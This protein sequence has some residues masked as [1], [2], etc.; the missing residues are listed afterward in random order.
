MLPIFITLINH[1]TY[2]QIILGQNW[3]HIQEGDCSRCTTCIYMHVALFCPIIIIILQAA[4]LWWALNSQPATLCRMLQLVA[5]ES[6]AVMT[7]TI[8]VEDRES[9]EIS[10]QLE[11]EGKDN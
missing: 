4:H 8:N 6:D 11:E 9:N 7:G 3:V 2:R 10:Q 5:T 1:G